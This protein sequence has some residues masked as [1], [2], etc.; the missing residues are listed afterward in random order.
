L[1]PDS[2][3]EC[4]YSYGLTGL[5]SSPSSTLRPRNYIVAEHVGGL[6]LLVPSTTSASSP[7]FERAAKSCGFH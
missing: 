1:H 4:M 3:A 5:V 2:T 7:A 6:Y